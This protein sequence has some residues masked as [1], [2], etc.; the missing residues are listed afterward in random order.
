MFFLENVEQKQSRRNVEV[1]GQTA[2]EEPGFP[3]RESIINII[4]PENK[5]NNRAKQREA[6]LDRSVTAAPTQRVLIT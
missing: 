3:S 5:H 4:N 6:P 2:A 1:S